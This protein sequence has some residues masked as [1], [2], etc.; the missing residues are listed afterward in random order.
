MAKFFA[1]LFSLCLAGV[2]HAAE[3]A[4]A[5]IPEPN[6]LGIILFLVIMFGCGG[7]FMW[8]VM[9]NKGDDKK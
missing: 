4:D 7:W 6:Y 3:I 8:R 1:L 9:R 2:A 5:P